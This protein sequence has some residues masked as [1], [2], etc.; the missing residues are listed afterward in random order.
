MPM[1]AKTI[2]PKIP[3]FAPTPSLLCCSL[4]LRC[5]FSNPDICLLSQRNPWSVQQR[6]SLMFNPMTISPPVPASSDQT[7]PSLVYLVISTLMSITWE[8]RVSQTRGQNGRA[9][10]CILNCSG[11]KHSPLG[12]Q[13]ITGCKYEPFPIIF[14]QGRNSHEQPSPRGL[15][16]GMIPPVFVFGCI[17]QHP[18]GVRT[19][20]PICIRNPSA[21]LNT[22][23]LTSARI[24]WCLEGADPRA[25]IWRTATRRGKCRRDDG[26]CLSAAEMAAKVR[27]RVQGRRAVQISGGSYLPRTE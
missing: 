4:S 2:S 18:S 22:R 9:L 23:F 10:R 11:K 16:T 27:H 20:S 24:G 8:L 19:Y 3:G 14:S 25:I 5:L 21:C 17:Q 7:M 26:A 12:T 1:D 15:I 13:T 6:L